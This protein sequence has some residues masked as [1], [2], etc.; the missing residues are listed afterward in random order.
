MTKTKIAFSIAAFFSVCLLSLTNA[1]AQ[2][3]PNRNQIEPSYEVVLQTLIA[4]N[5]AGGKSDVPQNLSGAVKKL[6]T[7]YLYS[8]YRLGAIFY[9]RVANTGAI[10]LKS[11]SSE[12]IP[13]Q[14]GNFSIFSEWT[15]NNLQTLPD[16]NGRNSIQF[17]N[18]RFGQ[19]I[20]IVASRVIDASGRTNAVVNYEQVGLTI[21]RCS[22]PENVP[23]VIGSVSTL[24]PDELM[25]LVL[26]VRSAE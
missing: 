24:K 22:L 20:P 5:I 23:T 6:K 9:Q 12:T 18:L 16:A 2:T 10:E 8:N 14:E 11:V 25:F 7:N 4:S 19:R 3:P 1:F 13:N 26:T 21:Q 17:Q 15:F